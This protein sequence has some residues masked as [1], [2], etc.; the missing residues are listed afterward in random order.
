MDFYGDGVLLGSR[1]APPY[2]FLWTGVSAGPH[3][4]T[5][6][7][8]DALGLVTSSAVTFFVIATPTIQIDPGIDSSTVA[9]DS[10]SVSGTAQA[11]PNAAVIV[12]GRGAEMG[13]D[14]RFFIENVPLQPG[15]NTITVVLNTQDTDP[16]TSSITVTRTATA[17]FGVVLDKAEGV[18]PFTTNVRLTNRSV[19]AFGRVEIDLNGDGAPDVTVNSLTNGQA[20]QAIT[21]PSPGVYTLG[22]KVFDTANVLVFTT[23][24]KV[25]AVGREELGYKVVRVYATLVDRLTTN[26]PTGAVRV[27]VGDSQQRY[28]DV[29]AALAGTLP[30]VAA[31]LGDVVSGVVWEDL[32]ELMI[33]R[34]SGPSRKLFTVH[35]IRG[36]DGIWRVEDM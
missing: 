29:L 27:F 7:A 3:T 30:S 8:H 14:G 12:G 10:V 24:R 28:A 21:F 13:R 19:A 22:F 25:R 17:P 2:T 11:P 18:A 31:Q 33:A 23:T 4:I 36:A 20:T 5:G 34:G 32:A 6:K 15:S 1:S 26:D 35:L 16:V 9:D